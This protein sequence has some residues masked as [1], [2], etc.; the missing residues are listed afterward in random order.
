MNQQQHQ[1]FRDLS[2]YSLNISQ[3]TPKHIHP[4][5]TVA[6]KLPSHRNSGTTALSGSSLW[7]QNKLWAL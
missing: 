3:G 5:K 7:I 6:S 2:P 4:M 1:F